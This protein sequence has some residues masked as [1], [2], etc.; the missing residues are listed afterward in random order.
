MQSIAREL[1]GHTER[2]RAIEAERNEVWMQIPNIPDASVP[3]GAGKEDNVFVRSWGEI[4]DPDFEPLPHWELCERLGL[5]DRVGGSKV[6]KA[7]FPIFRG[8]GAR[9]QRALVAFMLDLHTEKHGY[10]EIRPP[11]LANREAMTGTGQLPK[12]E[13]EMYRTDAD[14]LFLIP[15]AEVPVTNMHREEIL[16]ETD[17]PIRYVAYTPCFRREAG[18]YGR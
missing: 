2:L 10:T 17:L 14:D 12:R 3:S 5:L 13:R 1:K 11:L 15:T 4:P 8:A 6:A 16:S 7:G 9:L 18:S